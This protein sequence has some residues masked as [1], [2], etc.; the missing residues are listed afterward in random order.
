MLKL[1]IIDRTSKFPAIKGAEVRIFSDTMQGHYMACVSYWDCNEVRLSVVDDYSYLDLGLMYVGKN[2]KDAI[3]IYHELINFLKD[4]DYQVI[5][6]NSLFD[7]KDTADGFPSF[8]PD[9][10]CPRYWEGKFYK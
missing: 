5:R 8:F 9:L 6:E 4:I 10:G 3:N 1:S 7:Y 2:K